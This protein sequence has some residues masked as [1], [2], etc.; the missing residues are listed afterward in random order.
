MGITGSEQTIFYTEVTEAMRSTAGGGN[1]EEGEYIE[2]LE[3]PVTKLR[4]FV[5]DENH[6]KPPGC[7]FAVF[8]FLAERKPT[9]FI[10][11]TGFQVACLST[12]FS[13]AA[14]LT[15]LLIHRYW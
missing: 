13:L 4:D 11:S 14:M 7:A 1:V 6:V 9:P 3:I 5:F 10:N 15:A 8:W 12:G 2:T